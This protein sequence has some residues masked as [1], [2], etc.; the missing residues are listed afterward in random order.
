MEAVSTG[1]GEGDAL[2]LAWLSDHTPM[3]QHFVCAADLRVDT[4]N[5]PITSVCPYNMTLNRY[6]LDFSFPIFPPGIAE[7]ARP[8]PCRSLPI[9]L[10]PLIHHLHHHQ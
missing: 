1:D 2:Q 3:H 4:G 8:N 6:Q 10:S 7:M 9:G 5:A